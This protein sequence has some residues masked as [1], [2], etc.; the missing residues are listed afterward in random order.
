LDARS[1]VEH[2]DPAGT[3]HSAITAMPGDWMAPLHYLALDA[4]G[5]GAFAA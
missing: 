3:S 4:A 1:R 5:N 2:D